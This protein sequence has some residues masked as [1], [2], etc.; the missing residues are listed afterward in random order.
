[1]DENE[2]KKQALMQMMTSNTLS[3]GQPVTNPQFGMPVPTPGQSSITPQTFEN[4]GM[5]GAPVSSMIPGQ[6]ISPNLSTGENPMNRVTGSSQDLSKVGSPLNT[7][8]AQM[9]SSTV[10]TVLDPNMYA[11][12]G[13][14]GG[15][16]AKKLM[17]AEEQ[18]ANLGPG[19]RNL[20]KI[21]YPEP[22]LI[23]DAGNFQQLR[24]QLMQTA[25]KDVTPAGAPGTVTDI[26]APKE[27]TSITGEATP[28]D[29]SQTMYQ[30]GE[31]IFPANSPGKAMQIR[32]ALDKAGKLNFGDKVI[33]KLN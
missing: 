27:A 25:K 4:M 3:N 20:Q 5:S 31:H 14:M 28:I 11:S 17:T 16:V 7:S 23:D 15:Q 33:R 24:Q 21:L 18:M 26:T 22:K 32:D 9:A 2:A 12:P 30:V 1:M 6:P 13:Q 29:N 19:A 10:N 8:P